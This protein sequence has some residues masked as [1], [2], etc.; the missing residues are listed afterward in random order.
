MDFKG[1]LRKKLEGEK[2][3]FT[4]IMFFRLVSVYVSVH[5]DTISDSMRIRLKDFK[6]EMDG[7]H[8]ND[9]GRKIIDHISTFGEPKYI[10]IDV[11]D[12]KVYKDEN[13]NIFDHKGSARE[14]LGRIVTINLS[15]P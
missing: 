10:D 14:Y 7:Y 8:Y 11:W 9:M 15:A 2:E 3:A 6:D 13:E 4:D 12:I 5:R 1:L